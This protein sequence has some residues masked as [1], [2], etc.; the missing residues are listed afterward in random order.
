MNP[1][2][3][4]QTFSG[5]FNGEDTELRDTILTPEAVESLGEQEGASIVVF[6]LQTEGE[7]PTEGIEVTVNSDVALTDY[8]ANLGREPF[9]VGGEIVE[10]LFDESGEATG[11]RL[12]VDSPNA[13]VSFAVED[14]EEIETDGVE[15]ATFTLEGG[16][17][18]SVNE[19]NSSTVDFYDSL[20]TAPTPEGG[21]EVSL[22]VSESNLIETEGNTTTFT[23]NVDGEVPEDGLLVYVN[24][25]DNRGALGEFDVSGAEISGGAVPFGNFA[26]S[27]FYFNIL[28][29]GASITVP[30]FDETTNPEIEE[31]IVEGIQDYTFE[32]V[33]SPGYTIAEDAGSATVTIADNPDSQLQVSYS[34]EPTDLVESET[35]VG[36]HTFNL[37]TAPPEGGVTVSVDATRLEDF[38]LDA[39]EVMGGEITE[40]GEDGFQFNITSTEASINL[41]ILDDAN[42]EFLEE[43]VFTLESGEGY[44]VNPEAD[45]GTFTLVNIPEQV[46]PVTEEVSEPNDTIEL[47]QPLGLGDVYSEAS[48]AG[49]IDYDNSNRYELNEEET[50]YVDFTEDVDLYSVDLAAGDTVNFDLD[51]SQTDLEN[52]S[53]LDTALRIFDSEGNQLAISNNDAAPGETF[54]SFRDSYLEFT[55][56]ADGTYYVGVS[57]FPNGEFDFYD[58]GENNPY[59]ANEPASGTGRSNGEYTLNASLNTD[60]TPEATEI[61]PGGTEEAVTVS[62]QSVEGTFNGERTELRDTVLSPNLVEFLGEQEGASVLSLALDLDG[63]IPEDGVEVIINSD[64]ELTDYFGGLGRAPFAVGGE[65]VG[66]VYD[67]DGNPSGIRFLATSSQALINL[68][69][70]GLEEAETNGAENINFTLES[71][72]G[73]VVNEE[74]AS[75]NATVYDSLAD[76]PAPTSEPTVGINISETE[77]IE[78]EGT[79]TSFSFDIEGEI[80]ESGVLIYANSDTRGAIGEFDISS[81][82]ISGGVLPTANFGASGFFFRAFE[83]GASITLNVFDDTTNPEIEPEDALEGIEDFTFSLVEGPGYTIGDNSS[84]S[85]TIAENADSVAL[86]EEPEEGEGEGDLP[87]L[88]DLSEGNNTIAEAIATDVSADN[89][90]FF[91]LGEIDSDRATRNLVDASEDVDMYSFDL[92]AGETITVDV[93]SIEYEI[94]GNAEPQKLDSELRLFDGSGNELELVTGAPAPDEIFTAGR[95]PYLE[96]TAE[97]SGTYYVGVAQLGNRI[98]DPN[99]AGTGSGRI[100]PDSG[101]NIGEYE[102]EIALDAGEAV[103]EGGLIEG[104]GGDNFLEGS[105]SNDTILGENGNDTLLGAS[106]DDILR[107]GIGN[108]TIFAGV[109]NDLVEGFDGDD[110]LSGDA[111]NDTVIGGTGHD[112][113]MGVTGDDVIV[114]GDGS[115]TFISGNG[116]GTDLIRDFEMGVDKIGLVEGELTFDDLNFSQ[117]DDLTLIGVNE[118]GETLAILRDTSAAAFT[119]DSFA[120]VTDISSIDDVLA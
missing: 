87:F 49:S 89:S 20:E 67:N 41:P 57:S 70:E 58:P 16:D 96:Y 78:S 118:T 63:E 84:V 80:P 31:G 5:T 98:Y 86:P 99:E 52:A 109:G 69:L 34:V 7:I 65:V 88:P 95:D 107:G 4:L 62:L 111:G 50:L 6:G 74:S 30:A 17:G 35:T 119:E 83:D 11:F 32:L 40:V 117:L 64:V 26:A 105:D 75:I 1:K 113:I 13:L 48:V 38:N 51:A 61:T 21:P 76:A 9:T 56:E 116:D 42:E 54:I 2:I 100:F 112:S 81:A 93:D 85:Y 55:P 115:D 73:Y 79:E 22:N 45:G 33:P 59:E 104:D 120:S 71:S 72:A 10:A 29:D 46:P 28:E 103:S 108:D 36:V 3:S 90:T 60:L 92:N 43:A 106:G 97:E 66:A 82:E 12:R 94:E 47:A 27:G 44:Q 91:A 102:I 77:L 114:G 14:R 15:Q 110:L 101:I 68:P 18:Y 24:S 8:F 19:G 39:V 37:S 25:P 53:E 23:F